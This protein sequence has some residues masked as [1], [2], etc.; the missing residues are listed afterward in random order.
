[1]NLDDLLRSP[2]RAGALTPPERDALLRQ[3]AALALLLT[4]ATSTNSTPDAVNGDGDLISVE[5][6]ADLLH[7][8]RRYVWRRSR[9]RDWAPFVVRVSRKT[10]RLR[11]TGLEAWL[12]R[13]GAGR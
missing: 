2:E 13:Q 5:E 1:V 7:V 9:R 11:R 4:S 12:T 10:M 6:A 8:D 3:V